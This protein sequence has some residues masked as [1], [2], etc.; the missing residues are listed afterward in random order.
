MNMGIFFA[1]VCN[2]HLGGNARFLLL[3]LFCPPVA[4]LAKKKTLS[5][6][7]DK[8]KK[9]RSELR[10]VYK[11][12]EVRKVIN[13]QPKAKGEEKKK[14][15]KR[16]KTT[17]VERARQRCRLATACLSFLPLTSALILKYIF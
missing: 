2:F 17:D 9:K 6:S 5:S 16:S 7:V 14:R 11:C 8:R 12:L 1:S 10:A 13:I 3:L 4:L 15:K